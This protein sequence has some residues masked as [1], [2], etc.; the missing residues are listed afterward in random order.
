MNSTSRRR[1]ASKSAMLQRT[2]SE[3]GPISADRDHVR[4]HCRW[5]CMWVTAAQHAA[6]RLFAA[7]GVQSGTGER[8]QRG[9]GVG[10][11]GHAPPPTTAAHPP[12]CG[13]GSPTAGIARPSPSGRARAPPAAAADRPAVQCAPPRSHARCALRGVRKEW[14]PGGPNSRSARSERQRCEARG[15]RPDMCTS[16]RDGS[17]RCQ[18]STHTDAVSY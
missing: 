18:V 12:T 3:G 13:A 9:E 15:A 11:A 6:L 14:C 4:S 10:A 1:L 8:S 2:R 5:Q 17:C 16:D 7:Q